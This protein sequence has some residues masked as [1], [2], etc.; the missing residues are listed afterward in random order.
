MLPILSLQKDV[1]PAT[2]RKA[3][4]PAAVWGQEFVEAATFNKNNEKSN[5]TAAVRSAAA[6]Q[7]M[8]FLL[9][10]TKRKAKEAQL[11]L[12]AAKHLPQR[13]AKLKETK[14]LQNEKVQKWM[15]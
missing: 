10:D 1:L 13:A 4:P 3:S 6:K 15:R 9:D 11:Q 12:L 7:W 5:R 8:D 2:L 14:H